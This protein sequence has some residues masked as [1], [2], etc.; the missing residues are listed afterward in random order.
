L[1]QAF[2]N[3]SL[4]ISP[5]THKALV[6]TM[7]SPD[8]SRVLVPASQAFTQTKILSVSIR[9]LFNHALLEG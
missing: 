5:K 3:N 8:I 2:N 9:R 7:Q 6:I 1:K 4:C